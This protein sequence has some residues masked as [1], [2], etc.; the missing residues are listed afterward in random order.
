MKPQA[1]KN[2]PPKPKLEVTKPPRKNDAIEAHPSTT[3]KAVAKSATRKNAAQ[4]ARNLYLFCL[5]SLE[6]MHFVK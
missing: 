1:A 3:Q 5:I 6:N 4:K 2:D